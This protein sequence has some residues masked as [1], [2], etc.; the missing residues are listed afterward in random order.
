MDCLQKGEQL[1]AIHKL[2][3]KAQV[4]QAKAPLTALAATGIWATQKHNEEK[5]NKAF[6]TSK[7]VYLIFSV[8]KLGYFQGWARM[9]SR[10]THGQ[11]DQKAQWGQGRSLVGHT[12]KVEWQRRFDLVMRSCDHLTNP[13]NEDRPV[14]IGRDGQEMP[15]SVG[16]QLVGIIEDSAEARRRSRPSKP[17]RWSPAAA[18][19]PSVRRPEDS[20]QQS[21]VRARGRN[22]PLRLAPAPDRRRTI[23]AGPAISSLHPQDMPFLGNGL[24]G[25]AQLT[26][27]RNHGLSEREMRRRPA[28][29][30]SAHFNQYHAQQTVPIPLTGPRNICDYSDELR[31]LQ[32]QV[33]AW[34]AGPFMSGQDRDPFLSALDGAHL[35]STSSLADGYPAQRRDA[36]YSPHMAARSLPDS[37]RAGHKRGRSRS[38]SPARHSSSRKQARLDSERQHRRP[39]RS[40]IL[41]FRSHPEYLDNFQQRG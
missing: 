13:W 7:S 11:R 4:C 28:A 27:D 1:L 34:A 15:S 37:H 19:L 6:E 16:R 40:S 14:R 25:P 3:V 38:R 24:G 8:N 32:Q 17:E 10:I 36:I 26:F 5:L 35:D 12:F 23:A 22:A 33:S 2:P 29:P 21:S 39:A 9:V 31:G 18:R 20:C 41:D 30:R